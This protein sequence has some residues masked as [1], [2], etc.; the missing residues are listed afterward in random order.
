M[1]PGSFSLLPCLHQTV[2][3]WVLIIGDV[4]A[5]L[6]IE[7]ISDWRSLVCTVSD[8]VLRELKV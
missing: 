6:C 2:H 5:E 7:V 4:L 8:L 1:F 3:V